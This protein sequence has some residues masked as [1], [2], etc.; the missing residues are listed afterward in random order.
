MEAPM[1]QIREL[2]I[3]QTGHKRR[4]PDL[5]AVLED[6]II[7]FSGILLSHNWTITQADLELLLTGNDIDVFNLID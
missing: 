7:C 4:I 1:N 3:N 2:P 6:Q 5:I